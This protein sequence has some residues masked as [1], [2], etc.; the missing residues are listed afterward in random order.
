MRTLQHTHFEHYL[1]S[2]NRHESQ[3][4]LY[5]W[6]ENRSSQ[7]YKWIFISIIS[8]YNCLV[9]RRFFTFFFV[10]ITLYFICAT[11]KNFSACECRNIAF[12]W[13]D[14]FD[15][16]LMW[17]LN[18]DVVFISNFVAF[19]L[20]TIINVVWNTKIF[21]I[22][23]L[24]QVVFAKSFEDFRTRF[25]WMML[26]TF[27]RKLIFF[28]V[29]TFSEAFFVFESS[30]DNFDEFEQRKFFFR[31]EM[32]FFLF[33]DWFFWKNQIIFLFEVSFREKDFDIS[34]ATKMLIDVD[35]NDDVSSNVDNWDSIDDE[36]SFFIINFETTFFRKLF[37]TCFCIDILSYCFS[38]LF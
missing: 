11:F 25:S 38:S 8:I 2:A 4:E 33:N 13:R 32:L 19:V 9:Y 28:D 16:L 15:K 31:E 10:S 6:K 14:D 18:D 17:N 29:N 20:K 35:S 1:L 30:F 36:I 21:F 26:I 12:Q 3:C 22:F 23:S 24:I 27:I 7:I 34:I 37:N 5:I